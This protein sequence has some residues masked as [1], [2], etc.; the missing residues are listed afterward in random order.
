MRKHIIKF[1]NLEGLWIEEMKEVP[2]ENK[3]I[4]KVRSPRKKASCPYCGHPTTRVHQ[5]RKRTVIHGFY[6]NKQ[7]LLK[8]TMRRFLCKRCRRTFTE[9]LPGIDSKHY[10]KQCRRQIVDMLACSSFSRV[11]QKLKMSATTLIKFMRELMQEQEIMWPQRG[12][13]HLGIDGHSFSGH[14]MVLT[15]TDVKRKRLLTVLADDSKQT[16]MRFLEDIPRQVRNRITIGC[17]DLESRLKNALKESVPEVTIV[18]D[19][20][21]VLREGTACLNEVRTTIQQV[22]HPARI[23]KKLLEKPQEKLTP[24]QKK[25][26]EAIWEKYEDDHPSLKNAWIAKEKLREVYSA[27]SYQ[28]ARFKLE[29]LIQWLKKCKARPLRVLR[30]TLKRW[31]VYILNYFKTDKRVTNAY[32]EGIHTKFKLIKRISFGFRNVRNYICK[33]MLGCLPLIWLLNHHQL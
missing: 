3:T 15:V 28:V 23:P 16:L 19:K 10:T 7:V 25:R 21:H 2:Q 29:K 26:L 32:T 31:Q 20:Y 5:Y 6:H 27:S 33:I 9:S 13:I 8:A 30:G 24:D 18:A 11:A 17:T 22:E 4:I 1:F 14:D 12:E